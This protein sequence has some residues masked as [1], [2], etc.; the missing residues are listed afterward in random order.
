MTSKFNLQTG[1]YL[2]KYNNLNEG[3][4]KKDKDKP[5][6]LGG[7]VKGAAIGGVGGAG[8]GYLA[9][10]AAQ[11]ADYG[12]DPKSWP[13]NL[14]DDIQALPGGKAIEVGLGGALAGAGVGIAATAL[15]R[16][17]SK[18]DKH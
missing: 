14:K 16:W 18:G 2:K 7:A 13:P 3:A 5:S 9:G 10:K 11:E 12:I 1:G 15:A 6:Y 17:L 4:R 8:L